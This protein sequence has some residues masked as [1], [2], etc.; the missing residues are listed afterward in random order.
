MIGPI[1]DV[2][3]IF[4]QL[5]EKNVE[6]CILHVNSKKILGQYLSYYMN[7]VSWYVLSLGFIDMPVT[8]VTETKCTR[9]R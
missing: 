4:A 8:M 6:K 5:T 2:I 1:F 7:V 9:C 3:H